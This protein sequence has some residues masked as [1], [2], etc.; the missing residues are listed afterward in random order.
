VAT[1]SKKLPG[2]LSNNPDLDL[3]I[4]IN[5]DGTLTVRSGKV[6]IGQGLKTAA[7]QVAAE[8]LDVSLARVRIKTADTAE[9]ADEN[10]TSGSRSMEVSATALRF[11]AAECR[12][13]MLDMAAERLKVDKDTLSVDDGT[14]TSPAT[15]QQLTYWELMG[16]KKFARKATAAFPPKPPKDHRIVGT[17]VDRLDLPAKV[18]GQPAY[19]HDLD[20]P[21][22]AHGRIIRPRHQGAKLA[23]VD[24]S[25]AE[26]LPGVIKIVRD[27]GFLAVIAETEAAAITARA[28]LHAAA[29]WEAGDPLP[30]EDQIYDW[31]VS[32]DTIENGCVDGNH[33]DQAPAESDPPKDA[34]LTI[35]SIYARPFLLHGAMGPACTVAQMD[36]AKLTVY[37]HSQGVFP[38]R[39]ALKNVLKMEESDI[40]CIHMEGSGCYG[41]NSADDVALDAALLAR[42]LPGRPVRV[43][44]TRDDEHCWEP[45]G[46]AMV[47]KVRASVDKGGKVADWCF[48]IWS[49]NHGNRPKPG[50]KESALLAS[51]MIDGGLPPQ[52]TG[53]AQGSEAGE[54]RN[55]WPGY[56]FGA[57]NITKHFVKNHPFRTSSLRG[58]GAYANVFGIE[59]MMDELA[60]ASDQDAVA[61]RLAHLSDPRARAVIE[62]TA[63]AIGWGQEVAETDGAKKGLGIAYARY[64]NT[65]AYCAVAVEVEVDE[66]SGLIRVTRAACAGDAGEAIAPDNIANQL[67]GGLMQSVSWTLK[68]RVRFSPSEITSVDWETYPILTFREAPE[69]EAIVL[70]RPGEKFLGVGEASQSP[71]AA[72]IANA[73]FNV[74]GVRL[75]ELPFTPERVK[76]MIQE[77][78][79]T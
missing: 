69:V 20:L 4:G 22:M 53:P 62:A 18:F 42:A 63:E 43:Q 67:E 56:E 77:A 31:L 54:H 17:R 48:D 41:H 5:T 11:A 59:S 14:I 49:N 50:P 38:L 45:F 61:F 35:E 44:W 9:S 13:I 28:A 47:V 12:A 32:E 78:R 21:G 37:T 39:R 60:H 19:V 66:Q 75:R 65:A 40:R 51:R 68:E 72:A 7:A 27:G 25:A 24:T 16:G 23:S 15:N 70:N 34:A 55:A 73:V 64:K 6:E 71:T 57:I 2:S 36:G 46:T 10:V 30:N 74:T 58:L 3:W 52:S 29:R 8:E 33:T 79:R 1:A 76:A 26:S